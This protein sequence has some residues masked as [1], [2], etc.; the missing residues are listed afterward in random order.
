MGDGSLSARRIGGGR[1][2]LSLGH[3]S[4][5]ELSS[6]AGEAEARSRSAHPLLEI[7]DLHVDIQT[8]GGVIQAVRGVTMSVE[9]GETVG[10]VGESGSGKTMLSLSVLGLLPGA[11]AVRGSVRLQGRELVGARNQSWYEIRGSRVAMVFQDPMTA[12]NP[13]YSVGWQVAECI[14][15]HQ[16]VG[17][18]A[19]ARRVEELLEAVGLPNPVQTAR[20]FPHE[21]SGGM[22]QRVMIAMAIANRPQLL[23]AD[24]PTTALDVTVQA[25]ILD[26]LRALREHSGAAMI[27]ITHDLGVVAG[28]ADRLMIMYAG[29]AVELGSVSEVFASPHMPYTA[30]L[31]GSV[32]TIEDR[33]GRLST[34]PGIPP[35]GTDYGPGCAFA[36]RC[37]SAAAVCRSEQPD[38]AQVSPGH[39][40]SC[41]FA[42]PSSVHLSTLGRRA[43]EPGTS[44]PFP[45]GGSEPAF[46]AEATPLLRDEAVGGYAGA[47]ERVDWSVTDVADVSVTTFVLNRTGA[48]G[49]EAPPRVHLDTARGQVETIGKVVLSARGLTKHFRIRTDSFRSHAILEA[50]TSVNLDLRAGRC[51]ALVGETG[52]GKSTLGRLLL[53]LDDPTAGSITLE[54]TDITKLDDDTLRPLRRKMQM[55]FQDPYSSLNPRLSVGEIIGEPLIVHK[56]PDRDTHVQMLLASVGLDRAAGVRFPGEF[57]GGQRQRIGI[58][59]ALALQPQILVLDEPVSALDVSVQAS[60][61]NLLRDLQREL[62]LA[63]LFIAHDLAVVR[64]VADDVAVMYLGGIVEQGAAERIYNRPAH[65]YTTALLSAVPVPDPVR[66][67][68]RNRILLKGEIPSPI[69]PPS[70]CRFRTRCWKADARC[71]EERPALRLLENEHQVACHH[72]EGGF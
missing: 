43:Q 63:Y 60:V 56:V 36:P 29:K 32:P 6:G 2:L 25:Q 1:T 8:E 70:G 16:R 52:C 57:S 18:R 66:E 71:A 13:M 19:A 50:V 39:W 22:R 55:V 45:A 12:L 28:V 17:R 69:D 9:A 49:P 65:P 64:Q 67:R 68:A 48:S 53:R 46:G 3:R 59:R 41:H 7:S 38:L 44:A 20:R 24:E 58:A 4:R 35:S 10:V 54:G 15:L 11:A 51:L 61:L 47:D 72:P 23:I 40:A 62:G 31:L 34:I 30:G 37:P 5:V 42:A 27:L 14:Q 21:L 26:T 33:V